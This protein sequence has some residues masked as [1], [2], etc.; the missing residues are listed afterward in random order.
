[1]A[2]ASR[3]PARPASANP[4][5]ANNANNPTLRRRR[6]RVRSSTCSTNVRRAQSLLRQ[7]NRRTVSRIR[8]ARPLTG[9]STNCRW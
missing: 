7:K 3:A 8:T 6:R 2:A 1:M 5:L 9:R 4:T